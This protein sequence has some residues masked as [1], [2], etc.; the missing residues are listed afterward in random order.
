MDQF[1]R[2][3]AAFLILVV[4][5]GVSVFIFSRLG[6]LGR[7]FSG[8]KLSASSTT[9]TPTVTIPLTGPTLT[10]TPQTE[11]GG[12]FG[13]IGSLRKAPTITLSASPTPRPTLASAQ[14]M[15][16]TPPPPAEPSPAV[17]IVP[18][19]STSPTSYPASGAPTLI[20]PLA[21]GALFIGKKLSRHSSSN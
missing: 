9:P 16:A 13:W 3:L 7:I 18:Y 20:L 2:I 12:L 15:T 17:T 8:V 10:S 21:L 4:A 5:V 6:I 14:S 1:N 19:G 11:S